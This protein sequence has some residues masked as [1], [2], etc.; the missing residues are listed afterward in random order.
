M[1]SLRRLGSERSFVVATVVVVAVLIGAAS[2]SPTDFLVST[3]GYD[4]VAT[5][6]ERFIFR[7]AMRANED[8]VD[9]WLRIPKSAAGGEATERAVAVSQ[10]EE[11]A[12]SQR[13]VAIAKRPETHDGRL[14][15]ALA[16]GEAQPAGCAVDP[17]TMT[18]SGCTVLRNDTA[19]AAD[20]EPGL[21]GSIEC[22]SD[23][24]HAYSTSGGDPAPTA[25]GTQQGN[26]AFR[27]LSILDGDDFWGERCELGRNTN[28][29]GENHGTK[30]T[31]T[32]ALYRGGEQRITFFSER[33][34]ANFSESTSL[35]QTVAQIKQTQP[36]DNQ[37]DGPV[38]ELQ[39]YANRLRLQNSWQRAWTTRAPRPDTWI[40]YALDVTYSPDPTVGSVKAYVDLNGDGDALDTGEQSRRLHV[41]TQ[42]A[43]TDGPMGTADGFRPGD[44]IPNHLRLGLYHDTSIPCPPPSGCS[45]DVDNVQ[46]VGP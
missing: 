31:G 21:W 7:P 26:A 2:A 9:A 29:Y 35:W 20:P 8:L 1:P 16:H 39:L 46:V 13:P 23:S 24:R 30:R 6:P 25:D 18:A 22:A 43:E 37:G 42:L 15:L 27:R 44:P 40:R 38:L 11:A 28:S 10:V 41:A 5:G 4:P 3:R 19:A 17:R 34:P 32:F 14:M 36:A 33:Y 45:V 12:R